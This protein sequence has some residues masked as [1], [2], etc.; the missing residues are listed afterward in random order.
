LCGPPPREPE[1]AAYRGWEPFEQLDA[2]VLFGPDAQI[3]RAL[4]MRTSGVD[5]L[6]VVLGPSG[7]G[8]SSFLRAG[9]LPRL[10]P[11]DRHFVLLDIMRPER[12]AL[13]GDSGLAH[14]I[15]AGRAPSRAAAAGAATEPRHLGRYRRVTEDA[16]GIRN[17]Y[18]ICAPTVSGRIVVVRRLS[19]PACVARSAIGRMR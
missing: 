18:D 19:E 15:Y 8:K 17:I 13:S 6:F 14:A 7:S 9:L 1:R 4:D 11:D 2:G 3:V 5:S 12:R 16:P 10:R